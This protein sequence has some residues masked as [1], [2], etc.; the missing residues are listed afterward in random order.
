MGLLGMGCWGASGIA[1]VG[2]RG[3]GREDEAGPGGWEGEGELRRV[4]LGGERGQAV[5]SCCAWGGM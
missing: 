2:S 3:E 5:E 1:G 4:G